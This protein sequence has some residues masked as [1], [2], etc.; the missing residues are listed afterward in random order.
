[1]GHSLVHG[2]IKEAEDDIGQAKGQESQQAPEY[3]Y[4]KVSKDLL[5]D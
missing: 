1:M 2:E 4:F 5:H 3:K